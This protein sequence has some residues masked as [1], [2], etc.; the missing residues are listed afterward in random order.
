MSDNLYKVFELENDLTDLLLDGC[1]KETFEVQV[2]IIKLNKILAKLNNREL[3]YLLK[4]GSSIHEVVDIANFLKKYR[5]NKKELQIDNSYSDELK[6][7]ANYITSSNDN[8]GVAE[9]IENYLL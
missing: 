2:I 5:I 7:F 3:L 9:F 8:D 1:N 6:K 4:N